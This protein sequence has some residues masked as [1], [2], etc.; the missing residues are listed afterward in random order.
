MFGLGEHSEQA[1]SEQRER[2]SSYV[3]G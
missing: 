3:G 1:T 2:F